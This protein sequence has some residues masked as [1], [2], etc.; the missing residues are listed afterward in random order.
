MRLGKLICI[1]CCERTLHCRASDSESEQSFGQGR[2]NGIDILGFVLTGGKARGQLARNNGA[3][4][5]DVSL[6]FLIRRLVIG[7]RIPCIKRF[8]FNQ[9]LRVS[10]KRPGASAVHD[11][12]RRL[13]ASLPAKPVRTI[14][15]GESIVVDPNVLGLSLLRLAAGRH[16]IIRSLECLLSPNCFLMSAPDRKL[17]RPQI[18]L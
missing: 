9:Y 5:V 16:A 4:D 15:R 13:T 11:L 8:I 1:P 3:T 18:I 7:K 6:A 12:W 17:F 2:M 14:L 10:M